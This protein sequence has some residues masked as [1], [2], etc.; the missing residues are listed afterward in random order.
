MFVDDE[1]TVHDSILFNGVKVG[2]GAQ[3]QN[4][5]ID[6]DVIIP[7]GEQIGFDKEKDAAR[8][9]VTEKG[10]VVVPKGYSFS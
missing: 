2:K 6:K 1:A 4:C 10:V 7:A 5:I 9:T 3:I 8:F